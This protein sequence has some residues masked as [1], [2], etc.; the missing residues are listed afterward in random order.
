MKVKKKAQTLTKAKA[1][2]IS[3]AKGTVTF[4]KVSGNKKILI[5][6]AG[7]ITM[8]KGLKK[9]TYKLK[10]KIMAAGTIE[11]QPLTKQVTVTIRIK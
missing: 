1:F 9:G 8:K 3:K 2:T 7:K 6:K 5:N 4:K 10:V 11:Y